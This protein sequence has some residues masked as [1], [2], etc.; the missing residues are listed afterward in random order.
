[1]DF[2]FDYWMALYQKS[3]SSF[4]EERKR[5]IQSFI[6]SS[7]SSHRKLNGLQ[8]KID[9]KRRKAKSCMGSCIGISNLL[10]EHFHKEFTPAVNRL[11]DPNY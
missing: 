9:M 3:S 1:M 5:T 4:E 6:E 11:Y 8:F 7:F 2:N 10:M